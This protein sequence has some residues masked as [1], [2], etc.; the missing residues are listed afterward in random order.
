MENTEKADAMAAIDGLAAEIHGEYVKAAEARGS[1]LP[2]WT[3]IPED[4][5]S[6]CRT[7]ARLTISKMEKTYFEARESAMKDFE[8]RLAERPA[9]AAPAKTSTLDP[10]NVIKEINVQ[11]DKVLDRVYEIKSGNPL[12]KGIDSAIEMFAQKLALEVLSS[13]PELVAKLKDNVIGALTEGLLGDK[14][15]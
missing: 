9:A 4:A 13:S 10:F 15:E 14:E 6:M 5:K 1:R 12:E 3:E 11:I 8:K 7:L 2:A